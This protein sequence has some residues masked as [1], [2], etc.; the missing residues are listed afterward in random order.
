[1]EEREEGIPESIHR[2]HAFLLLD[3]SASMRAPELKSKMP[4][5]RAVAKMV[6]ELI[7]E[8][9][10]N[11]AMQNTQLTIVCYDSNNVKDV[12][13]SDYDIKSKMHY[14]RECDEK[15]VDKWDPL[16]GHKGNTPI[17]RA[18]AFGRELAE[19]WINDAHGVETRRGVIYLMSDGMVYPDTEPNGM[20]EIRKI[21]DFN[22]Q[23]EKLKEE[24]RY[25]GRIRVHTVGYYQ[26]PEGSDEEEDKGR[27]LLKSLPD[28]PK[29]YK[30]TPTAEEIADYI[31]RTIT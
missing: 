18:L 9:Y 30:E 26:L 11:P 1:M 12:R 25:K 29:A 8:L 24:G 28:N 13:L 16:I 31:I 2:Y 15:D 3:G 21:K 22:A 27:E 7:N 5:H 17:G 4:K 23:Q 6:Q 19:K 14:K 20:D 10:D